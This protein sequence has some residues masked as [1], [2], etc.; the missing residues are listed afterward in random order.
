MQPNWISCYTTAGYYSFIYLIFGSYNEKLD[1]TRLYRNSLSS[2]HKTRNKTHLSHCEELVF[3]FLEGCQEKTEYMRT[4]NVSMKT[5]YIENINI[6]C[7]EY[8]QMIISTEIEIQLTQS[9]ILRGKKKRRESHLFCRYNLPMKALRKNTD[10]KNIVVLGI[11]D[12][13]RKSVKW[14]KE[15]LITWFA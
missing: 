13:E 3:T 11:V 10:C 5:I 4:K 7:K 12:R 6:N 8:Q 2:R 1:Y 9:Y 14:I 15:M